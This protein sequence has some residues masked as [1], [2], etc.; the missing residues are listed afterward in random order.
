[1]L[2]ALN[3]ALSS[4]VLGASLV[5]GSHSEEPKKKS[6]EVQVTASY[7]NYKKM[8]TNAKEKEDKKK[9]EKIKVEKSKGYMASTTSGLNIRKGPSVKYK[10]VTSIEKGWVVQ[11]TAKKKGWYKTSKGW[12]SSKYLTPVNNKTGST[13]LIKQKKILK[14][15]AKQAKILA[16]KKAELAKKKKNNVIKVSNNYDPEVY[17]KTS[18]KKFSDYEIN[19]MYKIVNAEAGNEPYSGKLAVA[20]VILNR[21][22]SNMFPDSVAGVVYQKNQFSPVSNGTINKKPNQGSIQAVNQVI[23]GSGRTY[24][25]L[26]FYAP[27]IVHSKY[28]E[29]RKFVMR[30]GGHV[31]LR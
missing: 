9:K 17:S 25:I 11:V 29:S 6:N 14:E 7:E 21:I 28:L 19:L 12:I 30:I 23:S 24:G 10:I 31:F 2:T 18:N 13:A 3:T 5:L 26:F 27:S 16:K 4:L 1:M 8:I 15:R 20:S 22:D